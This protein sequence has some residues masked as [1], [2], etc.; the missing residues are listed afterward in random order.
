MMVEPS[1]HVR[2]VELVVAAAAA[3]GIT[4]AVQEAVA[5]AS[6]EAIAFTAGAA[7]AAPP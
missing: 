4:H 2:G 5:E 1:K 3:N 7:A 6:E